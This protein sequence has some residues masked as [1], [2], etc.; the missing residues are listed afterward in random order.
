MSSHFLSAFPEVVMNEFPMCDTYTYI[1]QMSNA[2]LV[3]KEFFSE[4]TLHNI[5]PVLPRWYVNSSALLICDWRRLRRLVSVSDAMSDAGG[6]FVS[7]Y[8]H[9]CQTGQT[10]ESRQK[11]VSLFSSLGVECG[12]KLPLLV[13]QPKLRKRKQDQTSTLD[14][15][16]VE[17]DDSY[18]SKIAI[19]DKIGLSNYRSFLQFTL[20]VQLSSARGSDDYWHNNN[21]CHFS[22][23]LLFERSSWI[24]SQFVTFCSSAQAKTCDRYAV[25]MKFFHD[26]LHDVLN[27]PK[28][29]WKPRLGPF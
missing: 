5:L 12:S 29:K 10:I 18:L 27:S 4:F 20:S 15:A 19:V 6:R 14:I 13:K 22:F 26:I 1:P 24:T 3:V 21:V 11:V 16:A 25:M 28:I 7:W 2:K 23:S 9:P 8:S 17:Q